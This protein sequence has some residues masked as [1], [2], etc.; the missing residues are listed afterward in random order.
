MRGTAPSF[1]AISMSIN[2][3]T[4]DEVDA[5]LAEWGAAGG[6]LS[7]PAE[8]TEWGGYSGYGRDPDATCGSSRTTRSGRSTTTECPE[9]DG[10]DVD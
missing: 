7:K 6:E 1:R 10:G 2:F 9:L 8:E 3:D 5:A 4:R